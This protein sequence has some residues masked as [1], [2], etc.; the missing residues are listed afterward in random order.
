[1]VVKDCLYLYLYKVL[2]SDLC[3]DTSV[4]LKTHLKPILAQRSALLAVT[5][6]PTGKII[7]Y[8]IITN[9]KIK[10]AIAIENLTWEND[11]LPHHHQ[12]QRHH[13]TEYCN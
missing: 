12:H 4:S 8:L 1:M 3:K 5:S 7:S 6:G 9:A 2:Y 11:F 13:H 10:W